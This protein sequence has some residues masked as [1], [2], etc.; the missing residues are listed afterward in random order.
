MWCGVG[1][2]TGELLASSYGDEIDAHDAVIRVNYPPIEGFQRHVGSKTTFDFTNHH[3][4]QEL[5]NPASD[6]FIPLNQVCLC[7]CSRQCGIT[8]HVKYE[9]HVPLESA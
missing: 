4:A 6:R 2:V 3:N 9:T 5:L 8:R 7:V 1:R